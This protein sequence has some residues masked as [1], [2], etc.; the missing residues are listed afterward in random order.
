M[1]R[2]YYDVALLARK[3]EALDNARAEVESCGRRALAIESQ[4]GPIDIWVNNAMVTVFSPVALLRPEEVR[5]V[6]TSR[7][8]GTIVQVG[9]ALAYRSIPLQAPCRPDQLISA[10][11]GEP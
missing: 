8:R 7:N 11:D 6:T 10:G 2:G 3:G 9:S 1:R 4:L 5:R